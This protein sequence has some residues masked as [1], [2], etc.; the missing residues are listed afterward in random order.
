MPASGSLGTP[1]SIPLG[2]E[3]VSPPARV[4]VALGGLHHAAG[5]GIVRHPGLR[6]RLDAAG[7][8]LHDDLY[9]RADAIAR[10]GAVEFAAG[11]AVDAALALP[12]YVRDDVARP[13]AGTVTVVS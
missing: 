2:A 4:A 6:A 8:R 7:M 10:L 3:Q 1:V 9:P 13:T 11:R 5:N 12:T